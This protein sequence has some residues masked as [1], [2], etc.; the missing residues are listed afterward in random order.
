MP[1]EPQQVEQHV[2]DGDLACE[3]S[4]RGIALDVHAPLQQL[5]TR[6]AG[7]VERDDLAVEHDI[8]RTKLLTEPAQLG[9]PTRHVVAVSAD[10]PDPPAVD[11]SDGTN[12]VPL[13]LV[14]P[15]VAR[16]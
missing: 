12:A 14:C 13:Q 2:R 11:V 3:P 15:T 5:E 10:E 1:V 16:R 8:A 7:V 6:T 4:N 9:I